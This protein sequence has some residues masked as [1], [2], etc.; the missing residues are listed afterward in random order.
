[1]V[2]TKPDGRIESDVVIVGGGLVGLTLGVALGSAGV[3]TVVVDG[4]PPE[5]MKDAAFDGRVSSIALGSMRVLDGIPGTDGNPWVFRGR[6]PGA[7]LTDLSYHWARI[8]A[9]AGLDGVRIHDLRHSYASRALALGEGL[10]TIGRLL[11]HAGVAT[12]ARYAHLMRDAEKA[13]AGRVGDS[14]R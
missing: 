10:A 9:R 7:H 2:A 5:A 3:E 11:G 12:T 14:S 6:K 4:A 13:A 1:M 8:A